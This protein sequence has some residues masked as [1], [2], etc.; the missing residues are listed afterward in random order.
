[1]QSN[2]KLH[3]EVITQEQK[4]FKD[5][6]DLV[7][8]PGHDGQIGILPGHIGLL[9]QLQAGELY[10]IKGASITILAVMKGLLDV[11]SD[12]VTVM[13]D[14][15]T[16]AEEIDIAKVEAA[17]AKAEQALKQKLSKRDY[18]IIQSDLRKAVLEL[19][20]VRK[21]RH[22]DRSTLG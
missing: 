5:D 12:N 21:H 17:K 11:N 2:K 8:A 14:S 22:F 16:R 4:V 20:V 10:I 15:A 19:K 1:M 18:A 6:V 13:T 9:T 3:L 7:L